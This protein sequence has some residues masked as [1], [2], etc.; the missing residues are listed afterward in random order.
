[1]NITV[2]SFENQYK[3]IRNKLAAMFCDGV[4]LGDYRSAW[5]QFDYYD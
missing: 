4:Y 1:M 3:K 5:R 2:F